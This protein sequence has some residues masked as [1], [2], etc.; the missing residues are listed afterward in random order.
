[1][2]AATQSADTMQA[3]FSRPNPAVLPA[4]QIRL[5]PN[6]NPKVLSFSIEDLQEPDWERN[7]IFFFRARRKR[8]QRQRPQQMTRHC[9]G[10]NVT[11][12][13]STGALP[14]LAFGSLPHSRFLSLK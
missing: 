9:C 1:M 12:N 2:P 3:V 7:I 10:I 6:A 11:Y 8:I 4:F 5:D 13:A 14:Q